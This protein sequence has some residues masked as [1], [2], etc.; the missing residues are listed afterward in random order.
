[1]WKKSDYRW[2]DFSEREI[3]RCINTITIFTPT[4]ADPRVKQ[5]IFMISLVLPS[6]FIDNF[7]KQNKQKQCFLAEVNTVSVH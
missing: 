2:F 1:M 4:S 5:N 3:S 6:F 7:E